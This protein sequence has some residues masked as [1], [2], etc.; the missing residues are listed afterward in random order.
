MPAELWLVEDGWRGLSFGC[1]HSIGGLTLTVQRARWQDFSPPAGFFDVIYH[2]PFGPV[3]APDCWKT[4]TFRWA[5]EALSEAGVL[6]TYGASSAARKAMREAGL[7]VGILPGAPGKREMTVA[8]RNTQAI[9]HARLWK[10]GH[11]ATQS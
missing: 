6:A 4:E 5:A 10:S 11:T 7:C 8:G 9:E 1:P 3:V 2:D